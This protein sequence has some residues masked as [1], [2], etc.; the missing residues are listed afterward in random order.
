M[1]SKQYAI[2]LIGLFSLVP[3]IIFSVDSEHARP[4]ASSK[5]RNVDERSVTDCTSKKFKEIYE[6]L[7]LIDQR[8]NY[9]IENGWYLFQNRPSTKKSSPL[10]LI[11]IVQYEK[12]TSYYL[13]PSRPVG[14]GTRVNSSELIGWRYRSPN[15]GTFRSALAQGLLCDLAG[16]KEFGEALDSL[17]A[18]EAIFKKFVDTKGKEGNLEDF[19]EDVAKTKKM[20]EIFSSL[21]QELKE[22]G[23]NPLISKFWAGMFKQISLTESILRESP[24]IKPLKFGKDFLDQLELAHSLI[25]KDPRGK[26]ENEFLSYID[27]KFLA[28]PRLSYLMNPLIVDF[29]KNALKNGVKTKQGFDS[30]SGLAKG[31]QDGKSQLKKL[32]GQDYTFD[33]PELSSGRLKYDPKSKTAEYVTGDP[34]Q[35]ID[36]RMDRILEGISH[37]DPKD[38]VKTRQSL[39]GK[40]S[41]FI[42]DDLDQSKVHSSPE[43]YALRQ[44]ALRAVAKLHTGPGGNAAAEALGRRSSDSPKEVLEAIDILSSLGKE[45]GLSVSPEA[46]ER[47]SHYDPLIQKVAK[48]LVSK[49]SSLDPLSKKEA[50]GFLQTGSSSDLVKLIFKSSRLFSEAVNQLRS[51]AA[52]TEAV[53]LLSELA[54]YKYPNAEQATR[55]QS[56]RKRLKESLLKKDYESFTESDKADLFALNL[57]D[58]YGLYEVTKRDSGNSEAGRYDLGLSFNYLKSE[59]ETL[60]RLSEKTGKSSEALEQEMTKYVRSHY[61]KETGLTPEIR[62]VVLERLFE[63]ESYM[64]KKYGDQYV[65]LKEQGKFLEFASRLVPEHIYPAP[66][67]KEREA[68]FKA[69]NILAQELFQPVTQDR[70]NQFIGNHTGENAY[71][72]FY[73]P[74]LSATQERDQLKKMGVFEPK[75]FTGLSDRYSNYRQKIDQNNK[76]LAGAVLDSVRVAYQR[77]LDKPS[78]EMTDERRSDLESLQFVINTYLEPSVTESSLSSRS[79]E[80][81]QALTPGSEARAQFLGRLPEHVRSQFERSLDYLAKIGLDKSLREG[82]SKGA[83]A[84]RGLREAEAEW[85][86]HLDQSV[87][88]LGEDGRVELEKVLESF[89]RFRKTVK[90]SELAILRGSGNRAAPTSW[91]GQVRDYFDE[92]LANYSGNDR[93]LLGTLKS[94]AAS[95]E[96]DARQNA[97]KE[98]ASRTQILQQLTSPD[99]KFKRN[100]IDFDP[101]RN[102]VVIHDNSLITEEVLKTLRQLGDYNLVIE[103]ERNFIP[104]HGQEGLESWLRKKRFEYQ[105]SEPSSVDG[106]G[107]FITKGETLLPLNDKTAV[108][109]FRGEDGTYE[110][111]FE[112]AERVKEELEKNKKTLVERRRDYLRAQRD[113]G[114]GWS[115]A[116]HAGK[117]YFSN[118]GN[119]TGNPGESSEAKNLNRTWN[120]TMEALSAV[121]QAGH[122]QDETGM[123]G[124]TRAQKNRTNLQGSLHDE[125]AAIESFVNKA[126]L[127]HEITSMI[128]T[129]PAGGSLGIGGAVAKVS[130]GLGAALETNLVRLAMRS[131]TAA[132]RFAARALLTTAKAAKGYAA[133]T[134]GAAKTAALFTTLGVGTEGAVHGAEY[135]FGS[136]PKLISE[137]EQLAKA[138]KKWRKYAE[139]P[140]EISFDSK[141]AYEKA[142]WEYQIEEAMDLDKDGIPNNHGSKLAMTINGSTSPADLL[143]SPVEQFASNWRFFQGLNVSK[144]IMPGGG[145]AGEMA[146]APLWTR[147]N[148]LFDPGF[149]KL[150]RQERARMAYAQSQSGKP[151]RERGTLEVLARDTLMGGV[152]GTRFGASGEVAKL[153]TRALPNS[154]VGTVLGVLSF[155]LADEGSKYAVNSALQGHA[156]NPFDFRNP[157]L[158]K[159]WAHSLTVGSYIGY[160]MVQGARQGDYYQNLKSKIGIPEKGRSQEQTQ[161][162]T[163]RDIIQTNFNG[164]EAQALLFLRNITPQEIARAPE[165]VQR[166][167]FDLMKAQGERAIEDVQSFVRETGREELQL[168]GGKLT[169]SLATIQRLQERSQSQPLSREETAQLNQAA[170]EKDAALFNLQRAFEG[171]REQRDS[172]QKRNARILR[173]RDWNSLTEA[174]RKK[175]E[176]NNQI[177]S[178]YE[179][180]AG[181][182]EGAILRFDTMDTFRKPVEVTSAVL[183]PE[184]E[185]SKAELTSRHSRAREALV[186]EVRQRQTDPSAWQLS[187]KAARILENEH[188]IPQVTRFG[189][190][191][192]PIPQ[193]FEGKVAEASALIQSARLK[194]QDSATRDELLDLLRMVDP[195]KANS[196]ETREKKKK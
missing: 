2:K 179:R 5:P 159:E 136:G 27:K 75:I 158:A 182:V 48:S 187:V 21:Q 125:A 57:M 49:F 111:K 195:V 12:A 97:G 4:E 191:L 139:V 113:Y 70:L 167:F 50:E 124:I 80:W 69:R 14:A 10:P 87:V 186:K 8:E 37:Q 141:E 171:T 188:V 42:A 102:A 74:D 88:A 20:R 38:Q 85:N 23:S 1:S 181:R 7:P 180:N 176:A 77:E 53:K 67:D 147:A 168:E 109:V 41:K 44:A 134:K 194:A 73:Q 31:V 26:E 193:G 114:Q 170:L 196:I 146:F 22:T 25:T 185:V 91:L 133:A 177:I 9:Q 155:I 130:P 117:V 28:E 145:L 13:P 92:Q 43:L 89:N 157:N 131:E 18:S 32:V 51:S 137:K 150:R 72:F 29:I 174:E 86:D 59:Q 192:S 68:Q 169:K 153:A 138:G 71:Q 56:I 24:R 183:S 104:F 175:V 106:Q 127:I 115:G 178:D 135:L 154:K 156:H 99:G 6:P 161:P 95:I 128:V 129:L 103:P 90:D 108:R 98:Q 83:E 165:V 15:D 3:S 55:Y 107:N 100:N 160:G 122:V 36:Q 82:K 94:L 11:P 60:T 46:I 33:D 96:S 65:P 166:E 81:V 101:V 63:D 132:G 118:I 112:D 172:A 120:E 30:D 52:D 61:G 34:F 149:N 16:K 152:E 39:Q 40:L 162:Q 140:M 17:L 151:E 66:T 121:E 62:R 19:E 190:P 116:W 64:Q 184:T 54:H 189:G 110:Y 76:L 45:A 93:K 164:N 119:W 58:E 47:F 173:N 144:Q 123:S 105:Y 78:E 79:M 84:M 142:L 126:E 163:I 35:R 143:W 148:P